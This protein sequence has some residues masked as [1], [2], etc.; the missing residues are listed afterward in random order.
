M[1]GVV[2]IV[3]HDAGG[4]EMVTGFARREGLR[5]VASMEGPAK[6][7]VSKKLPDWP[8]L[9][10][11]D[12]VERSDWLLCGSSWQSSHELHASRLARAAAKPV[13][14]FLDHWV[15]YRE[16]FL[17]GDSEILP[18]EIWVG[19]E[20][21]ERIARREFASLIIRNVGNPYLDDVRAELALADR[22]SSGAR[23][24]TV[25]YVC[26]PV[27]EHAL[28]Q[29]GDARHWGYTEEDALDYFFARR[30][31]LGL[32]DRRVVLRPHPSEPA[33]KYDRV[34]RR[35]GPSVTIGGQRSLAEEIADSDVVVGCESMAMVVGVVA[36]KRVISCVPPG[37]RA[38]SLPHDG[39]EILRDIV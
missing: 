21:A 8:N 9:S 27:A 30:A 31:R 26:E 29:Y 39:I 34:P 16:R 35:F 12:A 24:S 11:P 22:R 38:C 23:P 1:V 19:D 18:D 4:A 32:A 15:Q 2:A 6:A 7:I 20:Y 5:G 13:V 33:G 37:G 14:V 10:L 25:L 28:R 17:L 36:G 3:A